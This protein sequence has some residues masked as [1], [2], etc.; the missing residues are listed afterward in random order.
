MADQCSP[1]AGL[2]LLI[3]DD[4]ED[5]RALLR[6]M[7]QMEGAQTVEAGSVH[8][9][10]SA[11]DQHQPDVLIS[12]LYLPDGTSHLLLD[13]VKSLQVERGIEIL[14]L[15]VTAYAMAEDRVQALSAGFQQYLTKPFELDDL[16]T[17]IANLLQ[18]TKQE[19]GV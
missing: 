15:A 1:F 14:A 2:R 3:V 10:I 16:A 8:E 12:E 4:D 11:L 13:K 7:F 17:A 19:V 18:R 5:S 6:M 9:A